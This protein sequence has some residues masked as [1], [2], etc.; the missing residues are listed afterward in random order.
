MSYRRRSARVLLLDE[1]DR[2]LLLKTHVDPG[3]PAAGHAWF[4]PGGGVEVGE[5][6]AQAAARELREETGLVVA[7]EELG[8]AVAYTSGYAD[9]GWAEG[10]FRDDFFH[11]RV[12]RHT[13]DA[14]GQGADERAYHAGYRWWAPGELAGIAETVYPLGLAGLLGEL[15]AGRVPG[16][17]VRLPWHH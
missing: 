2:L 8:P 10:V 11:Y 6:L 4:T 1:A 17:P 3:D 5:T 7:P 13:V 9:L 15:V 16:E 12:A 14:G